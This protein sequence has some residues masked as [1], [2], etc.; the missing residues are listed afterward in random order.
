MGR[1]PEIQRDHPCRGRL[2]G[3]GRLDRR[4]VPVGEEGDRPWLFA[5]E[6]EMEVQRLDGEDR[7]AGIYT[8]HSGVHITSVVTFPSTGCWQVTGRTGEEALTFTFLL[9]TESQP[10]PDT[11]M[12]R[13]S[14][15]L[16]AGMTLLAAGL[17]LGMLVGQRASL[18]AS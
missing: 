5:G 18:K 9:L 4:E 11:A 3:A 10:T 13:P 7:P 1:I 17:V 16:A 15:M 14:P 2:G 6:L 12:Q 8:N